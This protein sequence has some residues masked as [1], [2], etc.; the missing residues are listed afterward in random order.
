MRAQFTHADLER[1]FNDCVERNGRGH[2]VDALL[3]ATGTMYWFEVADDMI[4][5]AMAALTGGVT[6]AHGGGKMTAQASPGDRLKL[7]HDALNGMAQSIY[8]KDRP[9][10]RS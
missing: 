2:A 3:K 8:S 9:N 5:A 4:A 7:V 6:V 10:A 1:A